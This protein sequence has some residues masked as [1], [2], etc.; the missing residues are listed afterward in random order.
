MGTWGPEKAGA[1]ERSRMRIQRKTVFNRIRMQAF[2]A[3]AR[4]HPDEY[5]EAYE[6]LKREATSRGEL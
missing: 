6:R 3:V 2:Q 5:V 4:K 1:Y